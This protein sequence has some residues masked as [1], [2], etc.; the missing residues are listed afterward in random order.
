MA[1][2]PNSDASR[3]RRASQRVGGGTEE[4]AEE[5]P[6]A[7]D[8][9][10]DQQASER[11]GGSG[12]ASDDGGGSRRDRQTQEERW[13][14]LR[15]DFEQD[16]RA[17]E[18]T[19]E[20]GQTDTAD[21]SAGV[22]DDF[23]RDQQQSRRAG[24]SGDPQDPPEAETPSPDRSGDIE[25]DQAASERVRGGRA[26]SASDRG[27]SPEAIRDREASRRVGG[28]Q[29]R[30]GIETRGTEAG[31]QAALFERQVVAETEGLTSASQVRVRREDDQLVAELT[32]EGR[33]ALAERRAREVAASVAPAAAAAGRDGGRGRETVLV[34]GAFDDAR[35]DQV[36]SQRTRRTGEQAGDFRLD[37]PFTDTTVEDVTQD[38]ADTIDEMVVDPT[39]RAVALAPERIGRAI[40]NPETIR[41]TATEDT[42]SVRVGEEPAAIDSDVE[43]A[44]ETATR[45]LVSLLNLPAT[46]RG[47]DELVV[48]PTIEI[49]AGGPLEEAPDRASDIA[50]FGAEEGARTL[51][52]YFEVNEERVEM[53]REGDVGSVEDPPLFEVEPDREA[54]VAGLLA[55]GLASVALTGGAFAATQGT[56][57]GQAARVAVQPGEELAIAAGRR[58]LASPRAAS[59]VPGVSRTEFE[60][61]TETGPELRPGEEFRVT[62]D[63]TGG[64]FETA[65]GQPSA[66]FAETQ[67]RSRPLSERRPAPTRRRPVVDEPEILVRPRPDVSR[68]A[69]VESEIRTE[70]DLD[71][72]LRLDSPTRR[73]EGRLA[74][75]AQLADPLAELRTLTEAAGAPL[76]GP[77]AETAQ[78]TRQE[79]RIDTRQEIR[80]DVTAEP[81]GEVA[82]E[83]GTEIRSEPRQDTRT[84]A[85]Q[86]PRF[87][88]PFE[89]ESRPRT[90][91]VLPEF[92]DDP[93][94]DEELLF[95]RDVTDATFETGFVSGEELLASLE[96]PR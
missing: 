62:G 47:L 60:F 73:V 64:D 43:I 35:R 18:R 86:E 6:L 58:G 78:D 11:V 26:E 44:T 37:I 29:N 48:E 94:D 67:Q 89:A 22:A 96:D 80:Q 12:D 32:A 74:E 83:I 68:E 79:T 45:S 19:P 91:V 20:S 34:E 51:D 14:R 8:F 16:Q 95:D 17:S 54:E 63:I 36:Q 75:R 57:A 77:A 33:E 13:A 30:Q 76:A 7:D 71:Q 61:G 40:A 15:G 93:L 9:E 10:Q 21:G 65:G 25:Q 27:L 4:D 1:R 70:A 90:E 52:E 56:R 87:E 24:G 92:E 72:P 41:I 55:G 88:V 38:F 85:R 53:L 28:A 5:N 82:L 39:A 50:A 49:A 31:R 46:A 42:G 3:D 69:I 84:E 59:L 2:G 66:L 23:E 81:R